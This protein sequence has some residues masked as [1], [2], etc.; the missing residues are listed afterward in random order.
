MFELLQA[1]AVYVKTNVT[2]LN[3]IIMNEEPTV[4]Y[5]SI[6]KLV[7]SYTIIGIHVH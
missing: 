6:W 7:K 2:S 3:N 1:F 5:L 4:Y